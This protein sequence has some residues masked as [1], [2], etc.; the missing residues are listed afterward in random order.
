MTITADASVPERKPVISVLMAVYNV[1]KIYLDAAIT[2]ILEQSWRNLEFIIVD[3]GS[4]V[5]TGDR[6]QMWAD[7]DERIR[8]HKLSTN[9]G[10]TKALNAGLKLARGDYLARQDADDI[11]E[12]RRLAAQFKFLALHPEVDAVGTDAVLIDVSGSTIGDMKID[13]EL[14]GLSRRNL[15][16]HGSMLFRRHVFDILGGYD[17]RMRLSQDYELYLRMLRFY[18][19]KIGVLPEVHYRLR[20][21]SASL[22]R[23][24]M[25]RQLYY[26]VMAKSLTE[27]H[28]SW[29]RYAFG[30][31]LDL[32]VD[33][34][35]THR[36]LLGPYIFCLKNRAWQ[37]ILRFINDSRKV[38]E[39]PSKT[40]Y[41][42][43]I[44]F[45]VISATF[46]VGLSILF[47]EIIKWNEHV[48]RWVPLFISASVTYFGHFNFTFSLLGNHR[49]HV[50]R[51]ITQLLLL[52]GL[53][54]LIVEGCSKYTDFSPLATT[55]V[56]AVLLSF[57]N[58][59][60][61]QIYTFKK[62]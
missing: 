6:L 22:S 1:P 47:V 36:L 41:G 23:R 60:F 49:K 56:L 29:F 35:L 32:T 43:Y 2:S 10:L 55:G 7:H 45:G 18:S 38:V 62:P 40:N 33:L 58:L 8:L 19:M 12:S 61:Y 37:S 20:Q 39:R 42:W 14:Q 44:V 46:Y 54:V 25:F 53:S 52:S 24:R 13:P 5:G 9:V 4:D 28:K 50:K 59:I 15:L 57:I 17:E 11:S 26:S 31:C 30:F 27:P 51:F 21:H 3:D 16:V 48:A 34:I